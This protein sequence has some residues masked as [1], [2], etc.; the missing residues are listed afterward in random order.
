MAAFTGH[1]Y[2][3]GPQ[4]TGGLYV[5]KELT[6]TPQLLGGTGIYSNLED[7]PEEMPLHL[8]AGTGNEPAFHGLLAALNWS[9]SNPL[10]KRAVATRLETLRQGLLKLGCQVWKLEGETTPV[11]SFNIPGM[12]PGEAGYLLRESY[13]IICR[14]GLHCAPKLMEDLELKEGTLRFSLSRF[15]TEKEVENALGAV[16]DLVENA[17]GI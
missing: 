16:K 13:D 10:D 4:G 14:S 7:M 3:L 1:K 2:L 9:R 6:L 5:S 15:T 11:V 8:E 12:S 17:Y